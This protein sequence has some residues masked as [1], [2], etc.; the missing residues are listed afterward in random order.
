VREVNESI[1]GVGIGSDEQ[2]H[3]VFV[4]MRN[5]LTLVLEE[6]EKIPAAI[7]EVILKNLLKQK[8]VGLAEL[9]IVRGV[10]SDV[11]GQCLSSLNGALDLGVISQASHG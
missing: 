11:L 9:M 6:S 1:H 3:N 8:K 5:V 10:V 7:V 2:P 4:A